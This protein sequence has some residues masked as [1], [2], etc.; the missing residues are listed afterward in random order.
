M[1]F[2][3]S[4]GRKGAGAVL[5]A[6]LCGC[7]GAPDDGIRELDL[8]KAA[9]EVRDLK[10]AEKLFEKS[11]ARAPED[12]DRLLLL[13]RVKID[14]GDLAAAKEQLDKAAGLAGADA[15]VV[16]LGAQL[17]WHM[18]D[19]AK[20]AKGFSSLAEN[21]KLD[22]EVRS[23]AYA[24]L[25]IVEMTCDNH[26][27]A[28]VAFLMAIRLDRR[29]AAA[30]YH[31][32]LLY[33]DGFDYP[34]AALEQFEIFVRLEASASPRV[35]KVQRRIIP[36]LKERIAQTAATRPG[37]AKRDS[38]ACAAAIAKAEAAVKKGGYKA[39]R[40]LYQDA[41]KADPMSYPAALGLAKAWQK[42]DTTHA[43]Q[44]KAFENYKLACMLRPGAISTFLSAGAL[45]TQL[46]FHVQAVEIY[47]RAFA[48]SPT[49]VEALDGL[50][51]ALTKAGKKAKVTSAYGDYR[52][53]ITAKKKR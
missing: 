45:A 29:N 44:V 17:A 1:S 14:L 24:E 25:G 36:G 43:G 40:P 5:L 11:L 21:P 2:S 31:L 22:A 46:G 42:T 28:R 51:R 23:Q 41:L 3:R 19:Y 9:Y 16:L 12:V 50:I 7:G 26:D 35:Q 20:A 39:A 34:E 52:K 4:F 6:A 10:K 53:V 30:W 15:D 49:S 38:A 47:S 8:G 18:K 32:G 37:V 27:L 33:R 48:A 13:T